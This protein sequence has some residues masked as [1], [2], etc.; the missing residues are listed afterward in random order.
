[1][2]TPL[3]TQEVLELNKFKAPEVPNNRQDDIQAATKAARDRPNLLLTTT[4]K[5]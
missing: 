1:M 4:S 5:P 3:T 2:S